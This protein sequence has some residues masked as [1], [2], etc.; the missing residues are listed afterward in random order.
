[1]LERFVN[2]QPFLRVKSE[3]LR[4]EIDSLWGRFREQ[5]G[6]RAALADGQRTDV[7]S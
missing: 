1:M 7:V 5:R 3:R 4:Q 6:E 2:S